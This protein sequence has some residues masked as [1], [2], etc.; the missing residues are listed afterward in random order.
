[1][2]CLVKQFSMKP[3]RRTCQILQI[4]T[5]S[6]VV[7]FD[8]EAVPAKYDKKIKETK[9]GTAPIVSKEFDDLIHGMFY[10]SSILKI[11]MSFF[12]DIKLLR[13]EYPYLNCFKCIIKNYFELTN[14]LNFVRSKKGRRVF[15]INMETESS[16]KRRFSKSNMKK[17]GGLATIA[18]HVTKQ[19]LS[20]KEQLSNWALRPLRLSQ[21]KYA[22]LDAQIEI[23]IYKVL[24]Q[25][26]PNLIRA[27]KWLSDLTRF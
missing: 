14:V 21:I 9:N 3:K 23:D 12:G 5:N 16:I 4:A 13:T 1:M 25:Q 17:E 27:N 22:A 18:R 26:H 15:D 2:E 19:R 8:L 24:E 20:K 6:K 11:G 10:D 7:L